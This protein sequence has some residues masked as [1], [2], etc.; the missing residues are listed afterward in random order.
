MSFDSTKHL[1]DLTLMS[2]ASS[3]W[4]MKL[5]QG[6]LSDL[7]TLVHGQPC[8]DMSESY[9]SLEILHNVASNCLQQLT[10]AGRYVQREQRNPFAVLDEAIKYALRSLATR[11]VLMFHHEQGF[12]YHHRSAE[13]LIKKEFAV[14][15]DALCFFAHQYVTTLLALPDYEHTASHPQ[16]VSLGHRNTVAA[17]YYAE[18]EEQLLAWHAYYQISRDALEVKEELMDRILRHSSES[19]KTWLMPPSGENSTLA[20]VFCPHI[21][22]GYYAL[23]KDDRRVQDKATEYCRV[24]LTAI[25]AKSKAADYGEIDGIKTALDPT[26]LM[27]TAMT[28]AL[29]C[30]HEADMGSH[31]DVGFDWKDDLLVHETVAELCFMAANALLT[32]KDSDEGCSEDVDV[33]DK[34]SSD[35]EGTDEAYLDI[36]LNGKSCN[37]SSQTAEDRADLSFVRTVSTNYEEWLDLVRLMESYP[38]AATKTPEQR[39][40]IIESRLIK[41]KL[42][43]L[44]LT[45][46]LPLKE[47]VPPQFVAKL[48]QEVLN[49]ENALK[50]TSLEE[51]YQIFKALR[52]QN[53]EAATP[54][55]TAESADNL[56]LDSSVNIDV[57]EQYIGWIEVRLKIMLMKVEIVDV[58][59][60]R[61]F[62]ECPMSETFLH[63]LI[64]QLQSIDY[65][66]QSV[67][68]QF[69][70]DILSNMIP[71]PDLHDEY[72][73]LQCKTS[74]D[75]HSSLLKFQ[76]DLVSAV[77]TMK[78]V[79]S[80]W[81]QEFDR[82]LAVEVQKDRAKTVNPS[83]KNSLSCLFHLFS[84]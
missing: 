73:W 23:S 15:S 1:E 47:T 34:V 9:R 27:L 71:P 54:T 14:L 57:L 70:E 38:S 18:Q 46:I 24:V 49:L 43:T 41:I 72:K 81:L 66:A 68:Q 75:I 25:K 2:R 82:L 45:N 28:H 30:C 16:N 17:H 3:L 21:M 35:G 5:K 42:L 55:V 8:H 83:N 11:K 76:S 20:A 61:L 60:G 29:K 63:K 59:D 69:E 32:T 36:V 74:E 39:M 67:I 33:D 6:L 26:K 48:H 4:F 10:S 50:T 77:E 37:N 53:A 80:C 58:A 78:S 65:D 84:V 7:A 64:M 22:M 51:L 52:T 40:I 31:Q 79:A 13:A 12:V 44:R 62:F 56:D 19:D